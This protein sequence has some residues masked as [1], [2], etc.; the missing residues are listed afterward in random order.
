MTNSKLRNSDSTYSIS[1][2]EVSLI[3]FTFLIK[4]ADK[5]TDKLNLPH[6][7]QAFLDIKY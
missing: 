7:H 1:F 3:L 4:N 6:K 5:I 2:S